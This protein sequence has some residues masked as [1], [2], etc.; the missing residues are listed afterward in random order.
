[1]V[2]KNAKKQK[3]ST[4][5]VSP[6]CSGSVKSHRQMIAEAKLNNFKSLDTVQCGVI[7]ERAGITKV[8]YSIQKPNEESLL[9]SQK[10]HSKKHADKT[11]TFTKT[12]K[13]CQKS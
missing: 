12:T 11:V 8:Q 1:M 6:A 5:G 7:F 13:L 2:R 10:K 3:E 4:T 9:K